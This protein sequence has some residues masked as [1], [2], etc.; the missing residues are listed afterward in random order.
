MV[1]VLE[2][3]NQVGRPLVWAGRGR[4]D[5]A[6]AGYADDAFPVRIRRHAFAP[7]VPARDLLVTPEHCILTAAGLTPARMLVN[8]ASILIDRS[9]PEYEFFHVELE[10]HGIL[11]SEG[12]AT[13][14]Y[15]DTG[16][17]G[18]FKDGLHEAGQSS[19]NVLRGP[20]M[21]A[22]L[23]VARAVV[24]PIWRELADR[25]AGLG[26][27][28]LRDAPVCTSQP[29]LRL[30]LEDGAEIGCAWMADRH[31]MFQIPRHARVVGLLSR[32][33]VPAQLIG[34]FVDDRRS[35]GVAVEKLVLWSGLD[36]T[37][38]PVADM[39]LDGWYGAEGGVRWTNGQAALDLPA[40]SETTYLDVHLAA[41]MLYA[42]QLLQAA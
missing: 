8:G 30:L 36:E 26:F 16:N 7:N 9:L 37:V 22:P 41:T 25:A 33:A 19:G 38:L 21:A 5:A 24:E 6:V 3:G 2:D 31:Y 40:A 42:E 39:A 1:S 18:L 10:T 34:P 35:L 4:M 17:R 15:L 12:L 23:A 20:T 14:S 13:E 11:L 28:G 27:E 32:S 29:D